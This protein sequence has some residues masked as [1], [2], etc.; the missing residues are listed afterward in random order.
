MRVLYCTWAL[1]LT[2]AA[3]ASAQQ[4]ASAPV[5]TGYTMFFRGSPVGREDVTIRTDAGGTVITGQGR[6]SL[7][8][9]L[10]IRNAEARY[11]P[12][13]SPESFALDASINGTDVKLRTTFR[14]GTAVTEGAQA[15]QSISLTAKVSPQPIVMPNGIFAAFEFAALTRR[16]AAGTP[17]ELRIFA[18]PNAEI[19]ARV[20]AAHDERMQVGTAVFNVRRYDLILANPNGDLA[21]SLTAGDDGTLIRVSVAAQSVDLI[22]NDVAA[23]TSRTQVYSN[24]GDEAVVIP[25]T[26]FNLGAT[27]TRPRGTTPSTR[28]PAVILLAGSGV[29]DR[30]G[31]ALGVP[32]LGQLAG[33]LADAGFLAVRYDKRGYGQSGGR[34][35]SATLGDYADDARAV[36]KWLGARKDVDPKR[37]ALAGHSEGA[38]VALL[39][40]ARDKKIAAVVSIAGPGSSGADLVLEQQQYAL[41]RMTLPQ[42]ERDAKVAQQKQIQS[43]VLSGRGWE[44]IAPEL[45]RQADT[46]WFQSLL[47]YDPIKVVG[48]VRQPLLIVHGELDRQVPVAHADRLAELARKESKSKSIDVVIVRGVNH[49][50]VPATTGEVSEYPSLT[51]RNVSKDV[52]SAI[53]Q[54]LTKTFQAVK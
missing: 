7:P 45:R 54:W 44:G 2:L 41:D 39:A 5:S 36:V 38:A 53:A 18:L 6:M 42:G 37:I 34:S 24:Q 46:P 13:W 8:V 9:D 15:G 49:L 25:S 23:S 26:G 43:A 50:L 20:T 32:T 21:V 33:A 40:A 47:A 27:L 17:A 10:Q 11:R 28:L 48:N 22:R 3:S 16:L 14:D 4:A 19:A 35:E 30:D 51:D 52:T 31:V 1:L 29:D 12:D